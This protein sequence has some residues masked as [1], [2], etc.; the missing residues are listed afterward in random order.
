MKINFGNSESSPAEIEPILLRQVKEGEQGFEE[1]VSVPVYPDESQ[2]D[3]ESRLLELLVQKHWFLQGYWL[4]KQPR[5]RVTFIIGDRTLDLFNFEGELTSEQLD[6]IEKVIKDYASLSTPKVFERVTAIVIDDQQPINPHT[7]TP[8]NGYGEQGGAIKLYPSALQSVG[9]RVPGVS[10]LEG[11]VIHELSHSLG[12]DFQNR[13]AREFDWAMLDEPEILPGGAQKNYQVS[14][15]NRCVTEYAQ[16]N[17]AED[18]C[19]S[20]VAALRNPDILDSQRLQ[21]IRETLMPSESVDVDISVTRK[22]DNDISVPKLTQPVV[23]KT[24]PSKRLV[25]KVVTPSS[26]ETSE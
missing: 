9:H 16:V 20:M 11:T 21:R 13:W 8:M 15:P 17:P 12:T 4:N 26:E 24:I 2:E 3:V 14:E 10:N 18:I 23:Y 1:A 19:E 22:A 25:F 6:Q 7:G 5:E